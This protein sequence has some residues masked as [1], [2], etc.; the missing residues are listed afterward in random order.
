MTSQL[1]TSIHLPRL[2]Q[3]MSRLETDLL[4]EEIKGMK[5]LFTVRI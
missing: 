5:V 2:V 1:D 4:W 3:T